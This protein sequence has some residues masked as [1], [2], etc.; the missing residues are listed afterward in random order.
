MPFSSLKRLL[1]R[2]LAPHG[3][4]LR[5]PKPG[6]SPYGL[7]LRRLT[8]LHPRRNRLALQLLPKGGRT[9]QVP[10]ADFLPRN[11]GRPAQT[12][13]APAQRKSTAGFTGPNGAA[14][15]GTRHRC[16]R[17]DGCQTQ[18]IPSGRGSDPTA[19]GGLGGLLSGL[20]QQK[21][22]AALSANEDVPLIGFRHGGVLTCR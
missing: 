20:Q 14:Y 17:V 5:P 21:K 19:L 3:R 2:R 10:G 12:T 4:G 1:G 13:A 9:A 18:P 15:A 8:G 22:R 16:P 7:I 6:A 11:A